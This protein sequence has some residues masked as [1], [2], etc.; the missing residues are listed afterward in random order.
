MKKIAKV[1]KSLNVVGIDFT[2]KY[3]CMDC[4]CQRDPIN[5]KRGLLV[6]E[7]FMWLLYI[8]PGVIYS[9][10]RRVRKQQVCP[11]CRYPSVVLTSS[12]RAMDMLRLMRVFSGSLNA[13][14][15]KP[16]PSIPQTRAPV[17]Q[18][19]SPKPKPV[20][21]SLKTVSGKPNP[22]SSQRR[23]PGKQTPSPKPKPVTKD[24]NE[25]LKTSKRR[26][27]RPKGQQGLVDFK[28]PNQD[29]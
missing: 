16:N 11:N 7:L 2:K 13:D 24:L 26:G 27:L 17:K 3:V 1:K 14:S 28:P 5:A 18:I 10:W 22:S 6:I 19:Q 23:V 9:I 12:S 4:G 21:G 8:L 25:I 15:G 20:A 29:K